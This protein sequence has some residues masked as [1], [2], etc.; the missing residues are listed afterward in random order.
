MK[1]G[2]ILLFRKLIE[3]DQL[4]E[5]LRRRKATGRPIGEILLRMGVVSRA[6]IV[7]ALLA[8]PKASVNASALAKV[9]TD[10]VSS[11]PHPL[12][13][14]HCCLGLDGPAASPSSLPQS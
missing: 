8:Q 11:V 2:Q 7:E 6:N 14:R 12:A 10:V 5:A 13:E 9:H 3:R 4:R 1:L